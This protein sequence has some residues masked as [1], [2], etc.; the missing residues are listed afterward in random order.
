MKKLIISGT[1][2]DVA[3]IINNLCRRY[4]K[5]TTLNDFIGKYNRFKLTNK[6]EVWLC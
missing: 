3:E 2:K 4:G 6:Q 5:E 1:P